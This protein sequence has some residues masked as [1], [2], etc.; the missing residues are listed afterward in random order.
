M[1]SEKPEL[2]RASAK[3]AR[4]RERELLKLAGLSER[5][6]SVSFAESLRVGADEYRIAAEAFERDLLDAGETI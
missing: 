6:G 3:R 2:W 1:D 5:L 4:Q